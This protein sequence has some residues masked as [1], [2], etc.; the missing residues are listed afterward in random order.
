MKKGMI[1]VSVLYPYSEGKKF[2]LEYY[3]NNHLSLLKDSLGAALKSFSIESGL[4]G[5]LPGS[6]APFVAIINM[7]FD[8]LQS[9]QQS[10]GPN[11]NALMA[12]L[13]NFTDIEPVAQISEVVL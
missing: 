6:P 13:P 10:F 3:S 12:D 1:K 7:Y 4:G 8:T 2:D 9:F 11:V 5:L